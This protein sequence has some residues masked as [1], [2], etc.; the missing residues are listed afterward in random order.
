MSM[1]R[2]MIP[3]MATMASMVTIT[4]RPLQEARK[5]YNS[6]TKLINHISAADSFKGVRRSCYRDV[7]ILGNDRMHTRRQPLKCLLIIVV[8][9]LR[10]PPSSTFV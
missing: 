4:K 2:T 5:V 8:P 7:F 10:P 9:A 3:T 1:I 6:I